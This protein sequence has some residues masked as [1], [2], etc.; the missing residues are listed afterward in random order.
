MTTEVGVDERL[1]RAV[2]LREKGDDE[3]ARALLLEVVAA[4]PDDA[5]ANLQCAW[6][7]DKLGL[8]TE[9][10]PYYEKAIAFGLERADLKDALL[11][12]GSTY[13]AIGRF[14]ES[15]NVFDRAVAEFPEA[16]QMVVFRALALY[17]SGRCKEACE[18]LLGQLVETTTD[19]GI[20][21]YERALRL[22]AEDLDRTWQ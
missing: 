2:S 14:S 3:Q 10:V 12:L 13:R 22:Y 7:H 5:R 15:L 9:A 4:H 16:R 21:S 17:N 11:G 6:V 18:T 20:G 19:P 8:E 1:A